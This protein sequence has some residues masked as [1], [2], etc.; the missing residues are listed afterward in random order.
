MK[1]RSPSACPDEQLLR[2]FAVGDLDEAD[3]NRMTAHLSSCQRCGETLDAI[4]GTDDTLLDI[5]HQIGV[6][7]PIL[8]ELE[9]DQAVNRISERIKTETSP[10]VDASDQFATS[11]EETE[12]A[13]NAV[14]VTENQ[15]CILPE[16]ALLDRP[17]EL[18]NYKLLSKLGRGGMGT[19]YKA[20]HKQL[21]KTVALKVLAMERFGDKM[22]TERFKRE[23]RAIGRVQHPN[24]VV[25]H[26]G[27]QFGNEHFLVMEFVDGVDISALEKKHGALPADVACEI[28]RQAAFG[29]QHAHDMGLVHRDI[30]PSN[31]MLDANGVVK[32]LDLGLARIEDELSTDTSNSHQTAGPRELTSTGTTMGTVGY[33]SPEQVL[34]SSKVD[35]R[36]DLYSLG[37]SLYKLLTGELPFSVRQYDTNGKMMVA[38]ASQAPRSIASLRPEL[39]SELAALIDQMLARQPEERLST[40]QE[41]AERLTPF[42]GVDLAGLATASAGQLSNFTES[43]NTT[44]Q[45]QSSHG[46]GARKSPPHAK[47]TALGIAAILAGLIFATTQTFW[48]RTEFGTLIVEINDEQVKAQLQSSGISVIDEKNNKVWEIDADSAG[49]K[50]LVDGEYRLEAPSGLIITD[51]EGL[52]INANE[53]KLLGP[54]KE[55]RIRVTLATETPPGKAA[56]NESGSPASMSVTKTGDASPSEESTS[57][58]AIP[59]D[60]P[61]ARDREVFHWVKSIG[62]GC[63]SHSWTRLTVDDA[64]KPTFEVGGVILVGNRQ[65]KSKDFANLAGLPSLRF[66]ILTGSSIDGDGLEQLLPSTN[67]QRLELDGT[68]LTSEDFLRLK[69]LPYLTELIIDNS[70]VT[71]GWKFLTELKSLRWLIVVGEPMS[72][73]E[74]ANRFRNITTLHFKNSGGVPAEL[75]EKL[76]AANPCLSVLKWVNHKESFLGINRREEAARHLHSKGW[77]MLTHM[78]RRPWAPE[79]HPGWKRMGEFRAPINSRLSEKDI[80]AFN[81]FE[82]GIYNLFLPVLNLE[83]LIEPLR[84]RSVGHLSLCAS[85]VDDEQLLRIGRNT[86]I[87]QLEIQ[88]TAVTR[89]GLSAFKQIQPCCRIVNSSFGT[90]PAEHRL[91]GAAET[92]SKLPPISQTRSEGP[93]PE[94][95]I[96]GPG[97]SRAIAEKVGDRYELEFNAQSISP[98]AEA[99]LVHL[100]VKG[101]PATVLLAGWKG[102]WTALQMIDEEWGDSNSTSV[103]LNPF[104]DGQ[105][106]RI[107][108]EVTDHS[109]DTILDGKPIISWMG[110]PGH[111]DFVAP[112]TGQGGLNGIDLSLF[113]FEPAKFKISNIKLT[114]GQSF[115]DA[116]SAALAKELASDKYDWPSGQPAAAVFPFDR[117]QAQLHQSRWAKHLGIAPE[118]TN[119]LGM[120][121]RVLPPGKFLM[122]SSPAEMAKLLRQTSTTHGDAVWFRGQILRE[123]PQHPVML[124]KPI[125]MGI[126]EVTRGQFR[127][128]VEATS[129]QSDIERLGRDKPAATESEGDQQDEAPPGSRLYP[130]HD[131]AD[132]DTPQSDDDPVINVSWNDAVAFCEWLS[133]EENVRYR[134]PTEAEW[135]FACR[136]GSDAKF[137]FGDSRAELH[138]YAWTADGRRQT[139]PVGLK[140]PNAFGLYDMHGNVF[141]WTGSV[142]GNYGRE[143]QIN[144]LGQAS[145]DQRVCRGGSW[146]VN[147]AHAR[148]AYRHH[149]AAD[150]GFDNLG[151]R[152]VREL[153]GNTE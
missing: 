107:R 72:Q 141:E 116:A 26:D 133:E 49:S 14:E 93:E 21:D 33:M 89:E 32:V 35:Q 57:D 47:L 117:Q 39:P 121:F 61:Y 43:E 109:L 28:I 82:P 94:D 102:T 46:G 62:G 152:I 58:P 2:G 136:A 52:Q 108:I 38:I 40:A 142:A 148:S 114:S 113:A 110:D 64:T 120:K 95:F 7:D 143:L 122:G 3:A 56:D 138:E 80:W 20:R 85:S 30:K 139:H 126:H 150:V 86:Q 5:L 4:Q 149:F 90:F 41:F 23:M 140:K 74:D 31:L 59:E 77:H 146:V 144:P 75:V 29:L 22:A 134:L 6:Q 151:F 1:K 37:A 36:S 147:H 135:E 8:E 16:D 132:F 145:G 76:Q 92:M 13:T 99:L 106:H 124:T 55:L 112:E 130:W 125:A 79:S 12:F 69:S 91:P 18:G 129:Y 65:L 88:G 105:P 15:P 25:A 11:F 60:D 111:L 45:A 67:I 54:D 27:G 10:E 100:K 137:C 48:V 153:D 104:S 66:A 101:R 103:Y 51:A 53:F 81:C 96:L 24:V 97:Q 34:D 128:F 115:F 127:R 50:R 19:V 70:Q 118:T 68:A 44:L 98:H 84:G 63:D 42:A 131:Q 123:G 17:S 83:D 119:R 78:D 87:S 73:I 71:D 9:L